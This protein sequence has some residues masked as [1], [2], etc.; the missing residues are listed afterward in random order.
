MRHLAPALAA[1]LLLAAGATASVSAYSGTTIAGRILDV[2]GGLPVPDA[3]IELERSSSVVATTST[4]SDGSF[5]FT[6][7][8]PGNYAVLIVAKGY[9]TTLS[10]DIYVAAGQSRVEFQTA[11]N[12]SSL[13][14]KTIGAVTVSGSNSLQSSTTINDHIDPALLQD[15][16]YIRSGDALATLPF[17]NGAT[18]SS[19]GDDLTLSI[20]GFDP[21]ETATLLDGHPIGPIGAFG[22]GFDFQVS[23]FWGMSGM[24]VTYGSGATG[25]YQAATIA[26]AVDFLTVNPTREARS[27]VAQTI[28]DNGK[29]MTGLKL[30]GTLGKLGYALADGVQGTDGELGPGPITQT[31]LLTSPSGSCPSAPNSLPSIRS[32]DVAA[33]TYNVAGT[34]AQRNDVLK[35]TYAPDPKTSLSLTNYVATSWTDSTGNGDTDN[36]PYPYLLYNATNSLVN[37]NG[38]NTQQLPNGNTVT[39]NGSFVVLNDTSAGY[40]CMTPQQYAQTFAGPFGGGVGRWHAARNQDYHARLTHQ[41]GNGSLV[42]DGFVDN[43]GFENVKSPVGPFYDDI[44]RTHGFLT[45]DEFTTA[46][47]DLSFGLYL[48]HQQHTGSTILNGTLTP[49]PQLDLTTTTYFL[50]DAYT[51]NQH[52]SAFG[53]FAVQRSHNTAATFFDPRLSLVFRPTSK[54]V[55]RVTG[56]RSFSEPDPSLLFGPFQY[57]AVQSFNPSCGPELNSIGSGSSPL[58]KPETANDFELA[59]GHRFSAHTVLQADAYSAIENDPLVGGTFPLSVVPSGQL[60]A[61]STI[62]A[63]VQKLGQACGPGYS[64]TNLGVSTTFNAGS[65][66]YR[67]LA[68]DATVGLARN[69]LLDANVAV[70]SAA[71]YGISDSILQT[72]AKLINGGQFRQIPLRRAS[73]GLGYSNSSGVGA[74]LDG[75]YVGGNN[76]FNRGPYMYANLSASR[77]VGPVTVNFGVYNLFNSVA[78]R[79]GYVGLGTFTPENQF[80]ADKNAFDQGSEEYG[81]PYRQLSLTFTTRL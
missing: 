74:Q 73:L 25:I 55:V 72:N 13:G 59:Y 7:Q 15:Q 35:L 38:Q 27:E 30:T 10:P 67:G 60:P 11:I 45:S 32:A 46:R 53:D 22:G 34:Y 28:G 6:S 23:P 48:Q 26:G 49:H 71:Y 21:G 63:F 58:L 40:Q 61:Q 75:Y 69:L 31:A 1:I 3:K 37:S 47:N 2:D 20:R 62:D 29:T 51:A 76:G 64:A 18:S 54:D 56:G 77:T 39:C 8:E 65:A 19:I 52:F 36:N 78:Q 50:R 5:K 57:G 44:Y 12:K 68:L 42:V 81:L 80:G 9:Q 33:C 70:Q 14:L 16:N 43:Y 79:Y 66:R 24:N 41:I 17:V 4:E